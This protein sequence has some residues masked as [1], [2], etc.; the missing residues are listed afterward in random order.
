MI[1]EDTP[2]IVYK[3]GVLN[4]N[5]TGDTTFF[6]GASSAITSGIYVDSG[7]ILNLSGFSSGQIV[8]LDLIDNLIDYVHD[9]VDTNVNKYMLDISIYSSDSG[10]TQLSAITH[11]GTYLC[12]FSIADANDNETIEYHMILVGIDKSIVSC[13]NSGIWLDNKVWIDITYW[14]DF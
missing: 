4:Y 9:N 13:F 10:G 6:S 2:V 8:R 7:F 1:Y 12:R 5:I 11:E 14:K 3:Y